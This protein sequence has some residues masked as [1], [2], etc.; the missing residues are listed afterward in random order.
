MVVYPLG[1]GYMALFLT[2]RPLFF[3]SQNGSM[4]I[5]KDEIIYMYSDRTN[6][7]VLEKLR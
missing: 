5:I 6:I 7:L 4:N 1:N 2:A 3:L